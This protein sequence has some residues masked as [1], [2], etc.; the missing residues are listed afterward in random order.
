MKNKTLQ[1]TLLA[2]T[3]CVLPLHAQNLLTNGDLEGTANISS[4]P[5]GWQNVPHDSGI[6]SAIDANHAT[7]DT[8]SSTD[9]TPPSGLANR[10]HSGS[11]FVSGLYTY[12]YQEGIQ[13]QVT[14]TQGVEYE[15]T[16]WQAVIK[17]ENQLGDSGSWL[18][19]ID[20]SLIINTD[21]TSSGEAHN[22]IDHP[23]ER[24]TV[25]FTAQTG[26]ERTLSFLA[27]DDVGG[28]DDVR[29]GIDTISLTQVPE[30]SSISLLALGS[31]A[32]LARR[33]R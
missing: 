23:W 14:L 15:I 19:Y 8:L 22:S 32:L 17:Q 3:T 12:D 20:D 16:L 31:L 1:I 5:A 21:I 18:I 4:V 26:G 33:K 10:P 27:Y 9:L 2:C 30:P 24:R 6:S 13:Q 7:A 28:A 25:R 29:M 11:T